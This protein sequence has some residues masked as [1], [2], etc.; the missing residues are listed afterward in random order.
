MTAFAKVLS[1]ITQNDD[2]AVKEEKDFYLRLGNSLAVTCQPTAAGKTFN[3]H[4]QSAFTW[5]KKN[6]PK[7]MSRE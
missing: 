3:N 7:K 1:G 4:V 6:K 5:L 2:P